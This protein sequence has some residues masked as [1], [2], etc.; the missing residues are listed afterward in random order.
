MRSL[1]VALPLVEESRSRVLQPRAGSSL[2]EFP[3]ER[4]LQVLTFC[5]P[6]VELWLALPW[7]ITL[8]VATADFLCVEILQ[9]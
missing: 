4:V 8:R 6:S 9:R 2:R 3:L 7:E 1:G 5:T